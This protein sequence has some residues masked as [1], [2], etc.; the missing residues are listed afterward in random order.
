ME[1][2]IN[3]G[4]KKAQWARELKEASIRALALS[5]DYISSSK[6]RANV[7]AQN[8]EGKKTWTKIHLVFFIWLIYSINPY[9]FMEILIRSSKFNTLELSFYL[10]FISNSIL[11]I[12]FLLNVISNWHIQIIFYWCNLT[13]VDETVYIWFVFIF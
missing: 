4:P 1:I 8:E 6:C 2:I 12:T 9:N 11:F 10:F 3:R 5:W 7:W 13:I